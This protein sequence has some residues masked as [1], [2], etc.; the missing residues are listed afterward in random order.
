MA[1]RRTREEELKA[2]DQAVRLAARGYTDR[3]IGAA[4]GGISESE[5]RRKRHNGLARRRA[6]AEGADLEQELLAELDEALRTAY[7]DHDEAP[8][9]STARVGCLRVISDL[10]A[11]RARLRGLEIE[12]AGSGPQ[13]SSGESEGMAPDPASLRDAVREAREAIRRQGQ[14]VIELERAAGHDNVRPPEAEATSDLQTEE[15]VE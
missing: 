4:L 15:E 9:D 10:I 11:R 3:E 14:R 12:R 2:E 8:A 6:S 7:R 1:R 13:A 5:A